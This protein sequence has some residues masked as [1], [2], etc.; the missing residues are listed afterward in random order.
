MKL[1]KLHDADT[2]TVVQALQAMGACV[3]SQLEVLEYGASSYYKKGYNDEEVTIF[4]EMLVRHGYLN[5]PEVPLEDINESMIRYSG[6]STAQY[7]KWSWQDKV[8]RSKSGVRYYFPYETLIACARAV[9]RDAR[10]R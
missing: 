4:A 7:A 8:L 3:E 6:L 5:P 10:K 9:V 1:K 2:L